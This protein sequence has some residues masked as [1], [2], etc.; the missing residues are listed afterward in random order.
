MNL[1]SSVGVF[2][3]TYCYD[4]FLCLGHFLQQVIIPTVQFIYNEDN[5]VI[6]T[7]INSPSQMRGSEYFPR[8]AAISWVQTTG[9]EQEFSMVKN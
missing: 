6:M 1:M 4:L 2:C 7:V 8:Q 3:D 5:D 9:F